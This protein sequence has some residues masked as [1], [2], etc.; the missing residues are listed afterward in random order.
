VS[1]LKRLDLVVQGDNLSAMA[2]EWIAAFSE[3][4]FA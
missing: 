3:F 1:F 2:S 4:K